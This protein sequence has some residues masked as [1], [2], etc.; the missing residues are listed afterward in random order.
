MALLKLDIEG[1]ESDLLLAAPA[2]LLRAIGQISVE[3]HDFL[4]P[5]LAPTVERATARLAGLGFAVF[6]MSRDNSDLLFVNAARLPLDALQRF[7]LRRPYRLARGLPRNLGRPPA[8]PR[9]LGRAQR[10]APR[11]ARGRPPRRRAQH[12][13]ELA[14][15]P[16]LRARRAMPP[17]SPM[18]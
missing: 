13:Q 11:Q 4:D 9:R 15:R 18:R 3:F 6:R 14:L 5:A 10:L 12:A 1:P 17:K 8:G 7:Y 16:V 2:E